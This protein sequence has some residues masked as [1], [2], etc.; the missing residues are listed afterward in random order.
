MNR[1]YMVAHRSESM[2]KFLQSVVVMR[3]V[4]YRS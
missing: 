1:S 3:S 2:H 4:E